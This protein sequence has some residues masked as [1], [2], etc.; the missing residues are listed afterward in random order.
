M[1][2]QSG[3]YHDCSIIYTRHP[4]LK[5]VSD[6]FTEHSRKLEL[7]HRESFEAGAELVRQVYDNDFGSLHEHYTSGEGLAGIQFNDLYHLLENKFPLTS[8]PSIDDLHLYQME[9][10]ARLYRDLWMRIGGD[11]EKLMEKVM[12]VLS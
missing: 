4:G 9:L 8:I 6:R 5:P 12:N 11:R 3:K 7:P 10:S 2:Q 1:S